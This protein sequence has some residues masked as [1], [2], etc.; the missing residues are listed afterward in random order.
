MIY[1]LTPEEKSTAKILVTQFVGEVLRRN[2]NGN[3]DLETNSTYNLLGN[4]ANGFHNEEMVYR[5]ITAQFKN[6]AATLKGA[7][8]AR[9]EK[10][11]EKAPSYI[12][13]ASIVSLIVPP[14]A[15]T[16]FMT[17]AIGSIF[18][19]EKNKRDLLKIL[20]ATEEYYLVDSLGG[21]QGARAVRNLKSI[22][23]GG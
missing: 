11:Q 13:A 22:I 18:L 15:P 14:I 17:F 3:F 10:L 12:I 7:N 23:E 9:R 4:Y 21:R 2:S 1:K 5:E 6:H 8:K 19:L 16:V 20:E